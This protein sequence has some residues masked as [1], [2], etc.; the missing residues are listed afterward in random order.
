MP[1]L[2]EVEVV[3]RGVAE[4]VVGRTIRTASLTGHRVA[5]RHPAGP[6]ELS[7][8]VMGT[9]VRAADRRGKYLWLVL[10]GAGDEPQALVIHLGM[11]GQLLVH[12]KDT[13]PARHTHATFVFEDG[14]SLLR[15]VDQRTFG[16]LSL[17]PLVAD[18]HASASATP[19][20]PFGVPASVVHIAPDP[21]ESAYD[22]GAVVRRLKGRRTA[23]KRALLDQ[24]VV[25]GIGNIYADEALWRAGVHGRR[26]CDLLT[27]P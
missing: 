16:G 7:E 10:A 14:G 1:E 8:R 21:L 24:G 4:H 12:A 26:E 22:R 17:L 11:S 13:E 2:P 27:K 19:G 3:R 5:R 6:A 23:I 15:F 18:P 9:T 25:S 20:H